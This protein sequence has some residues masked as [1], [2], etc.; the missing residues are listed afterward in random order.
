MIATALCHVGAYESVESP[1]TS[2]SVAC[3]IPAKSPV[4]IPYRYAI[5]MIGRAEATVTEPPYG[6]SAILIM[7][8]TV[9]RAIIIALSVSTFD[10]VVFIKENLL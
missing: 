8:S 6:I 10:F 5:M 3:T 4:F 7:L 2:W 9:E 1:S